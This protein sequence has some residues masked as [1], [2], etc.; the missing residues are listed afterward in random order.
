[1]ANS[2]KELRQDLERALEELQTIRDEIRVRMHLASMEAK[3]KW[4]ELEPILEKI[5]EQIK[6]ATREFHDSLAEL[7]TSFGALRDKL[8]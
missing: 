7:K 6:E 3:E 8:R 4:E 1:M 5:E 2:G